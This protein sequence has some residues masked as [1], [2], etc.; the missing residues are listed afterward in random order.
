MWKSFSHIQL[1]PSFGLGVAETNIGS[2]FK[3]ASKAEKIL[4]IL[5]IVNYTTSLEILV[6]PYAC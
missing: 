5:C 6:T 1:A 4:M 2:F 3:V